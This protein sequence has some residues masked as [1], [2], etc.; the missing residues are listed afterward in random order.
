MIKHKFVQKNLIATIYLLG[1]SY[2]RVLKEVHSSE[3]KMATNPPFK[4][5]NLIQGFMQLVIE[6]LSFCLG[7]AT[8]LNFE[9]ANHIHQSFYHGLI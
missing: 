8:S 5:F 7:I 9:A 6:S 2:I 3:V 4:S 1:L